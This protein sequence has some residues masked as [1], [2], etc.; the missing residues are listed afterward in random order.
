ME[1]ILYNRNETEVL[2]IFLAHNEDYMTFEDNFKNIFDVPV[3]CIEAIC[4]VADIT[5]PHFYYRET[6]TQKY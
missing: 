4:N 6:Y 2:G 5:K 1:K 3:K